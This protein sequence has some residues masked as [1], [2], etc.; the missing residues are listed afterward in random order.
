MRSARPAIGLLMFDWEAFVPRYVW[1][2][3]RIDAYP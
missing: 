1:L 2:R 3:T